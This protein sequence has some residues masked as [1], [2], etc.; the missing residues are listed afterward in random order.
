MSKLRTT[1]IAIVLGVGLAAAVFAFVRNRKPAAP[2]FAGAPIV[3]ISI[4]TLR[5][6][7]VAGFGAPVTAT[8]NLYIA[9]NEGIR[10]STAISA[11][12]ITAPSHATMLTGFS[13]FVHAVGMGQQG[14]A[15]PIPAGIPTLSELLQKA[16]YRTAA[17][18]DGIQLLPETGFNRGFETYDCQT[19]GLPP[20]LE[21]ISQFLD[22]AGAE[23]FFLFCHT[24]RAHQPYRAPLDLLPEVAR[25]YAGVFAAPAREAAWMDFKSSFASSP[26][27]ARVTAA[28]SGEHAK[29][30]ED[31]KFFRKL[32]DAGVTGAD[33]DIGELLQLLRDKGIY[34][35]AILIITSDHGEAFFEHG[36]ESHRTTHDE[37]VRV[38]FIM[39]LPGGAGAGRK[40]DATF[41]AVNIVP[42][43]LEVAAV[44][45]PAGFEGRSFAPYLLHGE[46]PE[47]PAFSSWFYLRDA[48]HAPG[49]SARTREGK[50]IEL[51][52]L[53]QAPPQVTAV[54]SDAFFDLINDPGEQHNKTGTGAPVDAQLAEAL[55]H[56]A[57]YWEAMRDRFG[58]EHMTGAAL[59]ED[60]IEGL[61]AVGYMG[62]AK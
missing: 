29:T 57:L 35:K 23:P 16:K 51:T 24:Y 6:D 55:R 28:L 27:Q 25:G 20:K 26:T 18:T 32:Y 1:L 52:H 47:T 62:G 43:L 42:T 53:E 58:V 49:R 60:A 2:Q 22:S 41:P 38:P 9:G 39:R 17:F 34:D 13:T 21:K 45:S 4:D 30:D 56:M 7:A 33:R 11:S 8:P 48:R 36:N 61:K 12:H 3:L 50:R 31:K 46:P 54:G 5:A 40:I 59:S 37:C 19:I 14:K 10:F 44:G 15:W